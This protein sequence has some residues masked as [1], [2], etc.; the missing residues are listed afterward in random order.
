LR[1]RPTKPALFLTVRTDSTRLP[2]K[3]LLKIG[4]QTVI[5]F[6]IQHLKRA[7]VSELFVLCTTDNPEDEILVKL[8]EKNG[9]RWFRGSSNDVL[10]RL[11]A[12][13]RKFGV[14]FVVNVEGDDIFCD[15]ILADRT[16]EHFVQTGADFIR[17]TGL[18]VGASPLGIRA[19]ALTKVCSLKDTTNTDTGWGRFFTETGLFRVETLEETDPLLHHPELRMTIDY[20]ED[21]AFAKEVCDRLRGTDFMLRDVIQIVQENPSIA[22]IN[23]H[24]QAEYLKKFDEKKASVR[25]KSRV[26]NRGGHE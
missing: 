7:R 19:E 4:N 14:D 24:R 12:A 1:R 17:W 16:F 3:V 10:A 15:P 9:I 13:A 25:L 2:G 21:Y 18:P 22:E 6:M 5:E 11:E 8:A 23:K 20:P 26:S